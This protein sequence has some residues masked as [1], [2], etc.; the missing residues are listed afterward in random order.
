MDKRKLVQIFKKTE[1]IVSRAGKILLEGYNSNYNKEFKAN[2][3]PVTEL[4]IKID[5]FLKEELQKILPSSGWLSE[6]TKD[7]F[8]RLNKELVWVVDPLDGTKEFIKRIPEFAISVSLVE[9]KKPVLGIVY[10]PLSEEMISGFLDN[11]IYYNGR[12]IKKSNYK[13][14]K[15]K[16]K[17]M[18]S[19][20]SDEKKGFFED[21]K[22]EFEVIPTGSIAYKLALIAIAKGDLV[23]TETPKNEWD[24]CAGVFLINEIGGY[25]RYLDGSK[26]SF[27]NKNTRIY[28]GLIALLN[29][30]GNKEF[31][32]ELKEKEQI[33][34]LF[35][36]VSIIS[37]VTSGRAGSFFVQSLLDNHKNILNIPFCVFT[38][39]IYKNVS[40]F[41]NNQFKINSII[42]YIS[43][44]SLMRNFL[45]EKYIE[46]VWTHDW[47]VIINGKESEFHI[48][49]V[50]FKK[51]LTKTLKIMYD[52]KKLDKKG[53]YIALHAAFA[54][55]IG[56]DLNN[57][58]YILDQTHSY[59][60]DAMKDLF[61]VD[62]NTKFI[63][64]IRDPRANYYSYCEQNKYFANKKKRF[65]PY[66]I[67]NVFN[68]VF[69]SPLKIEEY[70][71]DWL[72][73]YFL[74][75]LEDLHNSF[76]KTVKE[77]ANFL[78]IPVQKTL[79]ESTM[80][81]YPYIGKSHTHK[82]DIIGSDPKSTEPK[83][84]TCLSKKEIRN[85]ECLSSRF[86]DKHGYKKI[87]YNN[88]GKLKPS[89][90]YFIGEIQ[91][92]TIFGNDFLNLK[93]DFNDN[94][95]KRIKSLIAGRIKFIY[96][97]SSY[98]F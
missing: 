93:R 90:S 6:E 17:I 63:H 47:C 96:F 60:E 18:L 28:N 92:V 16:K 3:D 36:K 95:L 75:K 71:K 61:I 21:Y 2:K 4:D 49:P 23:L 12:K 59:T 94:L 65:L 7:D 32:E 85:I 54:L 73:N 79:F 5:R 33:K 11:G 70:R 74:I 64:T 15:N 42:D 39:D 19:S 26:P 89:L 50:K 57:I 88:G 20:R 87:Y 97:I 55:T 27:N 1:S 40:K 80:A 29:M 48:D 25:V 30:N 66:G 38:E 72:K 44:K 86:M 91:K 56:R 58:K 43:N 67:N 53:F 46:E 9:N 82:R 34:K 78:E 68:Y 83:W 8:S 24:I 31:I 84:K 77:L 37:I 22:E 62:P 69:H 98:K 14:L 52:L 76:E 10:N 41:I 13:N 81:G 45:L 51:N 35:E